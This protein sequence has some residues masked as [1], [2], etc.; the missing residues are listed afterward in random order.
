MIIVFPPSTEAGH[1]NLDERTA[2]LFTV[3][4]PM[5]K[6]KMITRVTERVLRCSRARILLSLN[7]NNNGN[8]NKDFYSAISVGSWRFT[9]EYFKPKILYI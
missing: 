8:N 4:V 5:K 7:N 2:P 6:M 1:L 9:T 3:N